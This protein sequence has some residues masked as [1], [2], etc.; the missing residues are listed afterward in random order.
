MAEMTR[1]VAGVGIAPL[2]GGGAGVAGVGIGVAPALV[3]GVIAGTGGDA[4][5]GG[6]V[7]I[8]GLGMV[9]AAG[10]DM[11]GIGMETAV[12]PGAPSALV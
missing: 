7:V 9:P 4:R 10:P 1:C 2:E 12:G 5:A 8:M 6:A 3:P 11:V